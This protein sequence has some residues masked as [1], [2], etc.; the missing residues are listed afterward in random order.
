MNIRSITLTILCAVIAFGLFFALGLSGGENPQNAPST[1]LSERPI[2]ANGGEVGRALRKWYAEGT[3]AG[4]IGD[5]YDNR[6]AGHSNLNIKPY[7]QLLRIE[8]AEEEIKNHQHW[9]MQRKILPYVVFGNSSTS[10]P[11]DRGGS[12]VRQYYASPGGLDFLFTQYIRNNLYI[13]PEHRDHDPGNNGVGGY[14]DLLPT[15]TPYLIASQGS[16]GSD[17]SFMKAMPYVLAAFRPDVKKKLIQTGMLMPTIQMILR[18]TSKRLSKPEEYLT[19]KAHPS[20][21]RG[22]DVDV[23]QM[24]EMA[25]DITLSTIPPIALLKVLKEDTPTKGIDYFEPE[26][27]EIL[28]DTPAVIARIF[29]GS[30]HVRKMTVSAQES[31]DLNKRPLKFH[32]VV[33]RGDPDRIQIEYLNEAHSMAEITIPYFRRTP[34]AEGSGL[35]SNRIDF[36]VFVHNGV[37]YSPPAFITF[38]TLDSEARTYGSDGRPLEIAYDVKTSTI[39]V[40]DW[41]ALFDALDPQAESWPSRFLRRHFKSEEISGL[42]RISDDFQKK[43]A[44]LLEARKKQEQADTAAK[45]ASD[46]VKALEAKYAALEK[47]RKT[48]Q[49]E[50]GRNSLVKLAQELEELR[51]EYKKAVIATREALKDVNSAQKSEEDVLEKE[52]PNLNRGASALVHE[53]LNS[54]LKNPD[55][56]MAD[57]AELEFLYKDAGNKARDSYDK[58][59]G[60]LILFGMGEDSGDMLVRLNP[61]RDTHAP[62]ADHLT[63]Y[64]KGMVANL[65]AIILSRIAFPGIVNS[66]KRERFVDFR[67]TSAKEWRDVYLYAPDETPMGWR[68]YQSDGISEFNADGLLVLDK[69]SQ[70]RCIQARLV[71]YELEPPRKDS[72]GSLTPPFRRKVRM[73]QTDMIREYEYEEAN[74]WQGHIKRRYIA[75]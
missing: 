5:Y 33:L 58:F 7:P 29:R 74:D 23:K 73:I 6:D 56:W 2:A 44:A 53:V 3:A 17:Q 24:V 10:A 27:T 62:S 66:E 11:L 47:L 8:Y 37:Y 25:H 30:N 36:G 51:E 71:R 32:W 13:Y 48:E 38:Y 69:D 65:N 49:G 43:H 67:I 1:R 68:R 42:N 41:T 20:V 19:G 22:S 63:H 26:Q 18:I 21:F 46:A 4:N 61:I 55:L 12:N 50:G 57:R 9:S 54:M 35:E 15:N 16:S 60:T 59:R 39:S 75:K 70:G 52:I 40:A 34:I 64:E 45:A 72:M 31:R 14:G 28:A